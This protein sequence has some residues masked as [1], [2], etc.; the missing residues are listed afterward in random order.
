[1][2]LQEI[3]GLAGATALAQA[4]GKPVG[5]LG[6]SVPPEPRNYHRSEFANSREEFLALAEEAGEIMVDEIVRAEAISILASADRDYWRKLVVLMTGHPPAR[7]AMLSIDDGPYTGYV[8]GI[9]ILVFLAMGA[10]L[11]ELALRLFAVLM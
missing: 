2:S 10:A 7:S 4:G 9:V 3:D 5:R 6:L 8:V 11:H 1:M